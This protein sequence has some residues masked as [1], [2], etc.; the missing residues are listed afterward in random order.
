MP[1]VYNILNAKNRGVAYDPRDLEVQSVYGT[2]EVAFRN[3]FYLT[4]SARSD[5]FSSLATPARD[6]KLNVVYPSISG[7]FVFSEFLKTDWL[8]FGKLRAGYAVVGQATDPYNTQLSYNF[9]SASLNGRPLG[10]IPSASVPNSELQPSKASKLEFGTEMRLFNNLLSVDLTWYNKKSKNEII[11]APAS[12]T[13]GY[14]GAVLN[15]GELQNKGFEALISA[16]P[17]KTSRFSWT[18]SVNGSVNNN[19]VL[20]LAAGQIQLSVGTSCSG[21]GFTANLV[22]MPAAQVST[23]R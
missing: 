10:V 16:T 23:L 22:G 17:V 20:S 19:K 15:I 7:A 21:A 1:F 4:G 18:T 3:F 5:W 11:T 9:L 14:T 2:L 6:N 8:S 13:S 12:I